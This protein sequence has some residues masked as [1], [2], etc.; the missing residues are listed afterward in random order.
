MVPRAG[1]DGCGK[2]HPPGTRPRTLQPVAGGYANY[3]IPALSTHRRSTL[4]VMSDL[5]AA[6]L[7]IRI[8]RR[9]VRLNSPEHRSLHTVSCAE[10]ANDTAVGLLN[11]PNRKEILFDC[12]ILKS[13]NLQVCK[14][15]LC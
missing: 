11:W 15:F 8:D 2:Y 5:R 1:L 12:V 7:Y 4:F 10:S 6:I 3:A 9:G 13:D 14:L